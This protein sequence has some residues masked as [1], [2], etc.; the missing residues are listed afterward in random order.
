MGGAEICLGCRALRCSQRPILPPLTVRTRCPNLALYTFRGLV[1]TAPNSPGA[2][3]E[4][5]A[6]LNVRVGLQSS[7]EASEGWEVP[8]LCPGL[9]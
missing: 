7:S 3:Q 1:E 8:F 2:V 4:E 5:G 6:G 9:C